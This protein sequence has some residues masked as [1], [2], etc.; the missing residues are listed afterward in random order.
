MGTFPSS[1]VAR[2]AAKLPFVN[3][4]LHGIDFADI[5]GDGLSYLGDYQPDLRIPLVKRRETL[6]VA[7]DTLVDSGLEPVTLAKAASRVFA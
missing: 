5:E 2:S 3:L 1:M 7:I 6:K 4:E